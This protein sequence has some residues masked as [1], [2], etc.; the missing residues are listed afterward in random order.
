MKTKIYTQLKNVLLFAFIAFGSIFNVHAENSSN[1]WTFSVKQDGTATLGKPI[2]EVWEMEWSDTYGWVNYFRR[3]EDKTPGSLSI[4]SSVTA[5]TISWNGV[6]GRYDITYGNT[7][8]VT[9]ISNGLTTAQREALRSVSIPNTV[10]TIAAYAFSNCKYLPGITIPGSVSTIENN[11]FQNDSSLV[12]ITIPESVTSIGSNVFLNCTSLQSAT[13]LNSTIG[14]SQFENC[15]ALKDLTLSNNLTKFDNRALANCTSVETLTIPATVTSFGGGAFTGMTG[16]KN[17]NFYAKNVPELFGGLPIENLNLTGVETIASRAFSKCISL[18]KVV[19]SES[20]KTIGSYAFQNDSSLVSITIPESVTSIESNIFLNCTSLQSATLLNSTISYSQFENCSALKDLTLSNN[21]TKID[22]RALVNCTSVETLTIPATVTSFGGGVFT[23]MTGLKNLNFYAKNVP[24]LFGGLPIENLNLTGAE[25]IASRAFTNC[26]DLKNITMTNS[27]KTINNY[28]FSGCIALQQIAIP[29]SITSIGSGAFGNCTELREVTVRWEMPLV[30]SL[31]STPFSGLTT[32]YIRLN[33][34]EGTEDA[35]LLASVWRAFLIETGRIQYYTPNVL[36]NSGDVSIS[37][38]G[39]RLTNAAIIELIQNDNS[40]RAVSVTES[41]PGQYAAGFSFNQIPTGKYDLHVR[42]GIIDTLITNA[43]TVQGIVY[44]KVVSSV[45]GNL[46]LRTGFTSTVQLELRN[47]GNIDA[48]GVNAYIVIPKNIEIQSERKNFREVMDKTQTFDFEAFGESYSI[49]NTNIIELMDMLH[50]DLKSLNTIFDQDYEGNLYQIYVPKVVA[51][52]TVSI[53]IKLKSNADRQPSQL[54]SAVISPNIFNPSVATDTVSGAWVDQLHR[55][56]YSYIQTWNEA[57]IL[58]NA[59]NLNAWIKT[60]DV[61]D[62]IIRKIIANDRE[63]VGYNSYG[64]NEILNNSCFD[65]GVINKQWATV[66]LALRAVSEDFSID[67][68]PDGIINFGI[69]SAAGQQFSLRGKIYDGHY[70]DEEAEKLRNEGIGWINMKWLDP[71]W[72]YISTVHL[73]PGA[74]GEALNSARVSIGEILGYNKRRLQGPI[75]GDFSDGGTYSPGQENAS[76]SSVQSRKSY[77]PNDITGPTGI[78]EERYIPVTEQMNYLIRFE[79]KAEAGLPAMFV[80][81]Y[82]T[83]DVNKYDLSTFEF[84]NFQIGDTIL[85]VPAFRKSYYKEYDM[86]PRLNYLVAI[87]A[88]LDTET[89]VAHWLFET[90]DPETLIAVEDAEAGF[91]LP[92]INIPEGEGSVSFSV[93]L[94]SDLLNNTAVSNFADIIFDFNEPIRTNL[95]SN[96]IDLNHPVSS[97]DVVQLTDSTFKVTFSA[98][99]MESGVRYYKLYAKINEGEFFPIGSF[100][101]DEQTFDALPDTLYSFYVEA[102]DFV[103][104][105]EQKPELAEVSIKLMPTNLTTVKDN[106]SSL[107]AT[108]NGEIMKITGLE[109]GMPFNIYNLQGTAIHKEIASVSEASVSLPARGVYIIQSGSKTLK[110][111][112]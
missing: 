44:P 25:T 67:Q 86:R 39:S 103:G 52:S 8:T 1:G 34:P 37:F 98:S 76:S 65:D 53:P 42:E 2:S 45:K 5:Q 33:I 46:N 60:I 27:L 88:N 18:K 79:N 72:T 29:S 106:Q 84:G 28:A 7:Y 10:T 32:R 91:L 63:Q 93:K 54:I 61:A 89:G 50:A 43:V 81:V 70:T 21:L 68:R 102:V 4:P 94:K 95:W 111:M 75:N 56:L 16:L 74:L 12:S 48:L 96:T 100:F 80:N 55:A 85:T 87:T 62:E 11:A 69:S 83:L 92:N 6:T 41:R 23:G 38:Y 19:L 15:S 47:T 71:L 20:M 40:V 109:T 22:N 107:R 105:A 104:N 36:G 26:S 66:L 97:A 31:S 3:Y 64:K 108:V 59:T 13:L 73:P 14:Y 30:L 57:A 112:Y 58:Q 9:S 24:E 78:V 101:E 82:D 51:G 77:D 110:V 35:Y 49:P 90:L 17:L 99:D